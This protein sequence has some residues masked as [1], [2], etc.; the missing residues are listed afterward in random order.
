MVVNPIRTIFTGRAKAAR[1]GDAGYDNPRENI[2][3]H[4]KTKVISTK[5]ISSGAIIRGNLNVSGALKIKNA[6]TFPIV[7]GAANEVLKTDGAGAVTWG[8]GGAGGG[9]CAWTSNAVIMWPGIKT[10]IVS[11]ARLFSSGRFSAA[12]IFTPGHTSG[13]TISSTTIYSTVGD[14]GGISVKDSTSKKIVSSL[15]NRAPS[16]GNCVLF[17]QND[18]QQGTIRGYNAKNK[19]QAEFRVGMVSAAGLF[20]SNPISGAT[21]ISYGLFSGANII[22][23]GHI[24][25]ATISARTTIS[26]ATIK[27]STKLSGALIVGNNIS[28][29]ILFAKQFSGAKFRGNWITGATIIGTSIISGATIYAKKFSGANLGITGSISGGAIIRAGAMQQNKFSGSVVNIIVSSTATTPAAAG[30]PE[31]TIYVQY[32]P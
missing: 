19:V 7:D 17:N 13:T 18:I 8:A 31:G 5:E 25:G 2:D 3:P 16:G 12:A 10:N 30:F 26:G 1:L 11:G 24:S 15:L 29:A 14:Y 21:I 23:S 6:Y 27:A 22:S 28:G 20:S 4:V 32:T 9:G